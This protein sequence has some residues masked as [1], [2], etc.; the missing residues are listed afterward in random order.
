MRK[1]MLGAVLA[2]VL[3][4][5][6]M[7]QEGTP[8]P[9][10]LAATA[11]KTEKAQMGTKTFKLTY[12]VKSVGKAKQ[13]CLAKNGVIAQAELKNAAKTCKAER[14]ADAAAFAIKYGTNENQRN[15][16]GKCV[17]GL[18]KSASEEE[19]ENRVSAADTCRT[20]KQD[21]TTFKAT[22]GEKKNAFGKCVSKTAKALEETEQTQA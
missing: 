7:A 11:C 8:S 3:P 15:A 19:T 14:D 13:A 22:F 4:A 2:L 12:A 18:A 17:S 5:A 20:L 16:Y 1:L 10:Q 9:E 21:A 6:A